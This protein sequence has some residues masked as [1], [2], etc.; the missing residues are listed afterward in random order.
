MGTINMDNLESEIRAIVAEVVEVDPKEVTL[1]ADFVGDLGMDSM[2][3]LEIMAAIEKKYSIQIPEEYL[4][5]I[6]KL[7]N[8]LEIAKGILK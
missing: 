6:M 2:K 8:L 5:K 1:E 3:A 7:S 4:G